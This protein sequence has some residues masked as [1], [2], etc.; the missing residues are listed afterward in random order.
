LFLVLGRSQVVALRGSYN[1]GCKRKHEVEY[2]YIELFTSMKEKRTSTHAKGLDDSK[3]YIASEGACRL[4]VNLISERVNC[5]E[6]SI[7]KVFLLIFRFRFRF[8][9]RFRW[10]RHPPGLTNMKLD[11][12]I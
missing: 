12:K 11:Q 6:N 10:E 1:D 4:R 2:P 8:I 5:I 3:D 9:F 7:Q